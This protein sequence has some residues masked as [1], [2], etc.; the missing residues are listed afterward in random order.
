MTLEVQPL[1]ILLVDD[2]SN[3]RFMIQKAVE[4]SR[5]EAR[6]QVAEDGQDALDYLRGEGRYADAKDRV[7][8]DLILLD[9]NMPRMGGL[10][11]LKALR[12]DPKLSD[13]PVVVL[14]TSEAESDILRTYDLGANWFLTKPA[15][16]ESLT[17]IVK[18]L[19]NHWKAIAEQPRQP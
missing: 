5:I 4:K 8:P 11:M 17:E 7:R 12:N 10:D 9:L 13:L 16:V 14:T 2:D 18:F 1:A 3:D 6:M 19:A 15:T